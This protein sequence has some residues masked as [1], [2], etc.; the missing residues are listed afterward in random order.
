M[1]EGWRARHAQRFPLAGAVLVMLDEGERW[2]RA[3]FDT[4]GGVF[5]GASR[6]RVVMLDARRSVERGIPSC[7]G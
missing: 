1:A 5:A 2:R 3:G 7:F 4:I 6:D